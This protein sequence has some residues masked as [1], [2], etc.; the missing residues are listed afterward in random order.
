MDLTLDLIIG[1]ILGVAFGKLIAYTIR[2]IFPNNSIAD[3]IG[4]IF[5]VFTIMMTVPSV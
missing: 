5:A 1:A 4:V 2:S 3:V